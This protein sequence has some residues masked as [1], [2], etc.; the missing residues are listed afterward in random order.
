MARALKTLEK[1]LVIKITRIDLKT[2][3]YV[4]KQVTFK[5]FDHKNIHSV[6]KINSHELPMNV[7]TTPNQNQTVSSMSKNIKLKNI[8]IEKTWRASAERLS[9]FDLQHKNT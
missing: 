2:T 8:G 1:S 9:E 7:L 6:T 5:K 4:N 3:F